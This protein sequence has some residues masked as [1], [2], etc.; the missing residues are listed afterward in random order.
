MTERVPDTGSCLRPHSP[1]PSS[2]TVNAGRGRCRG[3]SVPTLA[4]DARAVFLAIGDERCLS[5]GPRF[6][7]FILSVSIHLLLALPRNRYVVADPT[8]FPLQRD[9]TSV[10]AECATVAHPRH[11][12]L[13]A[14]RCSSRPPDECATVAHWP[15]IPSGGPVPAG[16]SGR[17]LSRFLVY[18]RCWSLLPPACVLRGLMAFPGFLVGPSADCLSYAFALTQIRPRILRS[19]SLPMEFGVIAGQ[20][21]RLGPLFLV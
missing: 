17:R 7:R 6:V 4:G 11:T 5:K 16:A 10:P 8:V 20:A 1:G 21:V 3:S 12:G 18:R 14:H 15:A 13:P 2:S 19:G 9:S